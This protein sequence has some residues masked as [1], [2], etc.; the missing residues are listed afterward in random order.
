MET[1][2]ALGAESLAP[3]NLRLLGQ[4]QPRIVQPKEQK[5]L[6][7]DMGDGPTQNFRIGGYSRITGKLLDRSEHGDLE[8]IDGGSSRAP[9]PGDQSRPNGIGHGVHNK[10]RSH[11]Q[12]AWKGTTFRVW[13]CAGR[14]RVH[15]NAKAFLAPKFPAPGK[16]IF[17]RQ[18]GAGSFVSGKQGD[19]SVTRIPA[20]ALRRSRVVN[21]L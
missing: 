16:A 10:L 12:T 6:L 8:A 7:G 1:L 15:E 17:F 14:R 2:A 9:S 11:D 18:R 4:T 3:S 20:M 13:R 21:D 5:S 19:K